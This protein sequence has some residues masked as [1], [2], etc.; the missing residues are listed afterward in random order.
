MEVP[1]PGVAVPGNGEPGPYPAGIPADP[2]A[3]GV[4]VAP[5][6]PG[7]PETTVTLPQPHPMTLPREQ[8]HSRYRECAHK[9]G[10]EP[11]YLR[12]RSRPFRDGASR[13]R[14]A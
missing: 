1:T 4:P 12:A 9:Q 5:V 10:I 8:E 3:P 7:T 13:R 6:A 11:E 14:R 2:G